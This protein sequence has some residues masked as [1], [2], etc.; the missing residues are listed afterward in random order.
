MN[1]FETIK[2]L[3]AEPSASGFESA[4]AETVRGLM[5]KAGL[6]CETDTMG[7][8][9]G[10][11]R[12]KRRNAPALLLD[13]H[14][15]EIGFIVTGHKK[16][17]L[18]FETLGGVDPRVL[19][20]RQVKVLSDPP[21]TGVFTCIPPHLQSEEE[22]NSALDKD[23]LCV[24]VGLAADACEK[25]IPVGTPMVFDSDCVRLKGD[26]I[27]GR[28]LDDRAGLAALLGAIEQVKTE[29][30]A[31][32]IV[33]V[34]S[35]QEEVGCRGAQVAG[36]RINPTWAL[37]VDVTHGT[38]PDSG[39]ALTFDLSSGTSIG[40]GPNFTKKCSDLLIK[41][42]REK[43]IRHTVEVCAGESG[44]NAWPLQ[45]VRGGVATALLSIPLRYMHTPCEVISEADVKATADL[46]AL[47]IR[48][49][50]KEVEVNA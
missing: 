2:T 40:V 28:A 30:L 3:C 39:K 29:D 9:C 31:M 48:A 13:A 11:L 36:W 8:V 25:L 5:E 21:C 12:S 7:N 35:V 15:D 32:D 46:A 24:D 41:L 43:E 17:F 20:A 16:G 23:K 26:L 47:Y 27:C 4:A 45:V 37:A 33:L 38:T 49:L 6:V 34:A 19:P 14:F 18:K 44:T 42:A 50:S 22:M 10:I 1:Y